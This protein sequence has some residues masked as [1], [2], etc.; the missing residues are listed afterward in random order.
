MLLSHDKMI[1]LVKCL[2]IAKRYGS[3]TE[4]TILG[5]QCSMYSY[6]DHVIDISISTDLRNMVVYRNRNLNPIVL[7]QQSKVLRFDSEY[8]ITESIIDLLSIDYTPQPNDLNH[9][10]EEPAVVFGE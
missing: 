10:L 1:Y 8:V 5:E 4:D 3:I 6:S 9:L 2:Y 7:V